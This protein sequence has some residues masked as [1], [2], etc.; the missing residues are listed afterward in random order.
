MNHLIFRSLFL[1]VRMG[2]PQLDSRCNPH[3]V[4]DF[5]LSP[6]NIFSK[7]LSARW[8]DLFTE[9]PGVSFDEWIQELDEFTK[10]YHSEKDKEKYTERLNF[11]LNIGKDHDEMIDVET[12]ADYYNYFYQNFN[13]RCALTKEE[14][15]KQRLQRL[16]NSF[17]EFI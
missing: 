8:L 9:N 16:C 14:L 2:Y 6:L 13:A 1:C 15:L 12:V 10:K 7:G 5:F 4:L 3:H 11:I 17:K